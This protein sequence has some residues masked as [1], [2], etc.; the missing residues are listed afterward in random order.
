MEKLWQFLNKWL[1][2]GMLIFFLAFIP[3]YPK[4]PIL[5]IVGTW[6]YIR[7]EDFLVFLAAIILGILVL[8]KKQSV[9]TPLTIPILTF[10]GVGLLSVI[11]AILFIF[12][13]LPNVFPHIAILH[14]LRRIEYMVLFFL[15]FAAVSKNRKLLPILVSVIAITG[16][17]IVIYGLGQ[18]YYGLPAFSTMNEEFA[19]GVPLRLPPTAR[20]MSTF[21]GHYDLAAYLVLTIPLFGS[22]IFGTKRLMF[23]VLLLVITIASFI[24][25][26]LTASRVSFG[27]Y[28]VTI[29]VMLWW[30]KKRWLIVPVIIAS[31]IMVN[32]VSGA[33]ERFLKTLRFNDVVVDLSTGK[34]IGTLEKVEGG[35]AVLEPIS[36]PDVENLPKGSGF[37]NVP[38]Q[39][40]TQPTAPIDEVEFINKK[41]LV[42]GEGEVATISGSYLIQKA[43]VLDISITT[44]FQ[45]QWPKAIA[46]F[47]RNI[48]TGSGYSSL[49]LA[50]DGNYHRMLGETGILGTVSFLGILLYA[51][52]WFWR[53]K[54]ILEPLERSFVT[55]LFAGIVGLSANAILID[56]F[57]ASKV[58]FPLWMMLGVA[59]ALLSKHEMQQ[60][61]FSVLYRFFTNKFVTASYLAIG[62]FLF[63]GTILN[64][65]FIGDDF[66]WLR[67]AAETS[68]ADIGGYFTNAQGFF[69]RPIPKLW[70]FSLFSIFWLM[71]QAYHLASIFLF[72][73]ISV[74]TFLLMMK[75]GINRFIAGL[76]TICFAVLAIHHENIIWISGQ[77]SLLAVMFLLLSM[78]IFLIHG[79]AKWEKYK[80]GLG[81][82][83]LLLA[84]GSWETVI[85]GPALIVLFD[86]IINKKF[87]KWPLLLFIPIYWI[88]RLLSGAVGPSGDYGYNLSKLFV[89]SIGNI[90]TYLIAIIVGP[91]AIEIGFNVREMMRQHVQSLT[92]FGLGVAAIFSFMAWKYRV[93]FVKKR[94][95]LGLMASIFISLIPF[96]GLGA[97][98]ERYALLPSVFVML[99]VGY[100]VT[101]LFQSRMSWVLKIVTIFL[102]ASCI[103]WNTN[104]FKRIEKEWEFAG[105]VTEQTLKSIKTGFFP[106]NFTRTFVF[107]DV[108]IRIGRAWIF[109]TGLNDALWHMFRQSPYNVVQ[110]NSIEA[111]FGYPEPYGTQ[112]TL[113]LFEDFKLQQLEGKVNPN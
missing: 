3:L 4:L 44:R 32:F 70:Y 66:T 76:L 42:A 56:V 62:M 112:K 91:R 59:M 21:A 30:Q 1:V 93:Y 24:L 40:V 29:S 67:W 75:V 89:N 96:V 2:P 25:L 72:F 11:L 82:F 53:K 57:E 39:G 64:Y 31:I 94:L 84:M 101:Q 80:L 105:Y 52:V 20:I 10:W 92:F 61:Y 68:T 103:W 86:W 95:M 33:S 65:Y 18:K 79:S 9:K 15:A 46:A 58:A 47:K 107:I 83:T 6:V 111:A 90:A 97:A 63:F 35:K 38:S 14:Y 88:I 23:K 17:L 71:P 98:S 12:P 102:I 78:N 37:I 7:L 87:T 51:F 77:S 113:L 54:D 43:F 74:L 50:A 99:F 110:V 60:G 36:E 73:V 85:V 49:N 106:P 41:Q 13:Q 27:V 16:V 5:D 104:E 34:P 108:P 26:L 48:L 8:F 28:L 100:V 69:Y 45:G 109:P 22:L 55:G 81:I 19:K